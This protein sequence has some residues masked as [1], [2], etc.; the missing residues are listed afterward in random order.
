MAA[1][2]RNPGAG[3]A[4]ASE[5]VRL[6]KANAPKLNSAPLKRNR[7]SSN[8]GPAALRQTGSAP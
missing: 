1:S 2:N 6:G 7:Q 3:G 8:R 5:T 4:R